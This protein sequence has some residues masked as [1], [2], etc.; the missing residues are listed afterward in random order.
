[1]LTGADAIVLKRESI[2]P[3]ECVRCRNKRGGKMTI[4]LGSDHAGYVLKEELRVVLEGWGCAIKDCG[5]YSEESV[6]YPDYAHEVCQAILGGEAE[7]GV[8]ICATGLGIS[9]A[10][11]RHKGIRAAVCRSC[12]MAYQ[13]R[14][15]NDANIIVYGARYTH[16]LDARAM[17]RI[18][19]DTHFSGSERHVCRIDKIDSLGSS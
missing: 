3:V 5:A 2:Y 11:N 16:F 13:A 8:L 7:R 12:D 4:A 10:A 6:D 17:L 1:M 14:S 15:H 19:L 9:M 18:F